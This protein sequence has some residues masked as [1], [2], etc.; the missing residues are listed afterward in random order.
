MKRFLQ[1]VTMA[2]LALALAVPVIAQEAGGH[3]AMSPTDEFTEA[4]DPRFPVGTYVV[5]NADHM[6]G[7]MGAGGVI[8][9]AFDTVLY[10]INFTSAETGERMENHRWVIHEE[11]EGHREEP[12]SVGDVVTL[13]PGHISGMGGEG[14]QAEIAEVVRGVAYMVDF[15]PTDGG[16]EVVNHQWLSEDELFA[17]CPLPVP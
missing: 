8:S 6:P 2:L 11:I 7:M 5:L 12:Y 17:C 13:M 16:E 10:A 4:A 9:G 1:Y 3:M 14:V 15:M